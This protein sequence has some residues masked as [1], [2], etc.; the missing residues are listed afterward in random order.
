VSAAG[1]FLSVGQLMP[2]QIEKFKYCL[3]RLAGNRT[4]RLRSKHCP[5]DHVCISNLFADC[6]TMIPRSVVNASE[7]SGWVMIK[8]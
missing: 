7:R 6:K 5:A 3:F 8:T 4:E 1:R 2:S